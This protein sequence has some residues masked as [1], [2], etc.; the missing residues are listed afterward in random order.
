MSGK[1]KTWRRVRDVRET[2][3][4]L[5]ISAAM[6]A[7]QAEAT[8]EH[9]AQRLKRLRQH[10]GDTSHCATGAALHAQLEL[11]QRLMRADDEIA[12]ALERARQHLAH[13]ERQ[14]AAAYIERETSGKLLGR[15]L[16]TQAEIERR[17][18]A[19]T[20]LARRRKRGLPL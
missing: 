4:Q 12:A 9:N 1:L 19:A 8:L 20:P 6:A 2:Q 15:A 7:Q 13:T 16:D 18:L 11:G 14:R 17:K 10:A 3:C 5:A